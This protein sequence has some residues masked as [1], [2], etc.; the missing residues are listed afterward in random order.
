MPVKVYDEVI[1]TLHN[2]INK[3]KIG[4]NDKNEAIKK[5]HSI[6]VNAEK[7]FTPNKNFDAL[8]EKERNESWKYGG[9]TVFGDAKPPKRIGGD[10]LKLF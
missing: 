3:A 1:N 7:N 2:A 6:A 4:V 9:K 8:I 10:Q 5:L